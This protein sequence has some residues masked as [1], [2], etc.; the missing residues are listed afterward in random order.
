MKHFFKIHLFF[1]FLCVQTFCLGK[2]LI[3]I[4][5]EDTVFEATLLDNQ[6]SQAFI[7]K[8]PLSIPME[9][10]N[11]NEKF[12]RFSENFPVN[13]VKIEN[14]KTGDIVFYENNFLVIFYED[15][16]TP[17]NYTLIGTINDTSNL[18][19]VLKKNKI[20]VELYK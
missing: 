13:P 20:I 5:I 18:K 10:F 15:F 6:T 1:L 17:Y 16:K 7:K 19:Q 11:Q 14:I 3:K 12:Y 4:K 9:D 8:L 2:N